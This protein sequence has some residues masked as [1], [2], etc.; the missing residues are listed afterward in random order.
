MLRSHRWLPWIGLAAAITAIDLVSRFALPFNL[1]RVLVVEAVLFFVGALAT[2]TLSTRPPRPSGWRRVLP[3]LLAGG[4]LLAAFRAALWAAGMPVAR[5]NLIIL[6]LGV[7]MLAG[8]Q[9][10]TRRTKPLPGG[11]LYLDFPYEDAKFRYEQASGKVFRRF[12]GQPEKEIP[13]HSALY[14]EAMSAGRK[15]SREEYYRD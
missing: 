11:D 8:A 10:R 5:A 15:T 2:L 14:H 12:Y 1:Q 6:V 7:V 13:A 4:L 9:W 3:R